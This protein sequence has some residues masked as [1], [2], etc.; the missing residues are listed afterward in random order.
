MPTVKK[1][2]IHGM[3]FFGRGG[4]VLFDNIFYPIRSRQGVDKNAGKLAAAGTRAE[5]QKKKGK[6]KQP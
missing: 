4:R 3:C 2:R 5:K 1:A 6:L